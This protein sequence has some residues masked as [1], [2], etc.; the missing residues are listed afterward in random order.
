M[1]CAPAPA[2]CPSKK[3]LR[4]RS[5]PVLV[6]PPLTAASLPCVCAVVSSVC[7]ECESLRGSLLTEDAEGKASRTLALVHLTA[8]LNRQTPIAALTSTRRAATQTWPA[9]VSV[10]A[11]P[12]WLCLSASRLSGAWWSGCPLRPVVVAPCSF[13][14]TRCQAARAAM[15]SPHPDTM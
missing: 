10:L 13:L 3:A 9:P 7:C 5:P 11:Q 4:S 12:L 15:W 8:R 14:E 2:P 1:N 6:P